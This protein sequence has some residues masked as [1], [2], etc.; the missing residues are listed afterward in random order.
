MALSFRT[1]RDRSNLDSSSNT[2]S[3]EE[4]IEIQLGDPKEGEEEVEEVNVEDY[5][6]YNYE[7]IDEHDRERRAA[8]AAKLESLE[9]GP[10]QEEMKTLEVGEPTEKEV[11]V[12]EVK[13]AETWLFT[14]LQKFGGVHDKKA[15]PMQKFHEMV[16]SSVLAF[17]GILLIGI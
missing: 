6:T 10:P 3:E 5:H 14:Y 2:M 11:I 8:R 9:E 1:I 12:E 15:P 16:V 4:L 17:T 13:E 7:A